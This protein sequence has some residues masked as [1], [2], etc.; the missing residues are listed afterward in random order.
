MSA[1]CDYDESN[2]PHC[3]HVRVHDHDRDDG[4]M[5]RGNLF[6]CICDRGHGRDHGR[7]RDRDRERDRDRAHDDAK[8]HDNLSWYIYH[9][10]DRDRDHGHD[11]DDDCHQPFPSL[12]RRELLRDCV[13]QYRLSPK[14]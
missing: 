10:R 7:G 11:R 5:D 2:L 4:V 1:S 13:C 8:D 12:C 3:S 14:P 6:W 9:G